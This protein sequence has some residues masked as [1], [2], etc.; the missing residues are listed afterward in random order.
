MLITGLMIGRTG[1]KD[2]HGVARGVDVYD[3]KADAEAV[4][5]AM[6]APAKVQILRGAR[7]WWHPGRHGRI[8]AMHVWFDPASGL[9]TVS[10]CDPWHRQRANAAALPAQAFFYRD[11]PGSQ[12]QVLGH[13]IAGG[14]YP[15]IADQAP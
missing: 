9:P 5:A 4:L 10:P 6:G 8:W 1:P 14:V 12:A 11:R 15:T 13:C 7:E 3:V 2:V